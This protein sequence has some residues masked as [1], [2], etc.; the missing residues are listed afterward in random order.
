M[1][2]ISEESS[3]LQNFIITKI[4]DLELYV[5]RRKDYY[6]NHLVSMAEVTKVIDWL[7]ALSTGVFILIANFVKSIKPFPETLILLMTLI[8]I[9]YIFLIYCSFAFKASIESINME[10]NKL[11]SLLDLVQIELSSKINSEGHVQVSNTAL[12]DIESDSFKNMCLTHQIDE[13]FQFHF[14]PSS[15]REEI[16][17]HFINFY[18]S[19]EKRLNAEHIVRPAFMIL[20]ILVSLSIMHSF[21]L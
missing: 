21:L 9:T 11:V 15:I 16:K 7:V 13:L 5:K 1:E 17:S 3:K 8:I 18:Q 19:N 14:Y 10:G 4:E 20:M 2:T 12:E 6:L